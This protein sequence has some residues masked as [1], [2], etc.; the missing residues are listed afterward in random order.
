MVLGYH[1][2]W[3]GDVPQMSISKYQYRINDIEA[4]SC[5]KFLMSDEDTTIEIVK[6]QGDICYTL[7]YWVMDSEGY[8][9]KFV[10]D[11]PFAVDN[12]TFWTI[13]T[14][15]QGFLDKE[16]CLSEEE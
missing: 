4:R 2:V 10:G 13:A 5:N 14:T 6:W 3:K 9:L 11:R 8:D 7:A 16:F 12:E 1:S 15:A